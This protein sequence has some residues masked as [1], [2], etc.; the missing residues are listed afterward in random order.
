MS[1]ATAENAVCPSIDDE[2]HPFGRDIELL[3]DRLLRIDGK[4]E[5]VDG[6][7]VVMSPTGAWPNF[8]AGEIFI[9][10]RAYARRVKRG[11]AFTDNVAFRVHLPHR[12]SFSPDA[13]Y[14]IGPPAKMG[15]YQVAPIFAVEVRSYGDY[16]PRAERLLAEKREDYF[17]CGTQVVWD[18][19]LRS[20]DLIKSYVAANPDNPLVFRAGDIAN[21]EPAVPGWTVTLDELLPE[22]WTQPVAE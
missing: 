19:D 7:V 15:P 17:A 9:S 16:G 13:G 5:I 12:D 6:K 2:E 14:Y 4:A 18:V 11:R 8:V 22:D 20:V 21:A 1:S 10:L 3:F